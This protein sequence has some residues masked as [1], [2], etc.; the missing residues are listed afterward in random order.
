METEITETETTT[1]IETTT[2]TATE[3][4][5]TRMAITVIEIT[6]DVQEET[7]RAFQVQEEMTEQLQHLRKISYLKQNLIQEDLIQERMIQERMIERRTMRQRK[8]LS[9][10]TASMR[11]SQFQSQKRRK[12]RQLS[13]L[14]YQI[15]SL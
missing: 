8:I 15:P 9:L 2:A 13:S 5:T 7:D 3:T 10:L 1:A 6:M 14:F 12:R 4:E 11:R